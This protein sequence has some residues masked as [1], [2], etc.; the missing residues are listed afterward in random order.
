[1]LT[2]SAT[3]AAVLALFSAPLLLPAAALAQDGQRIEITGSRI[4]RL[5]N[6]TATQV[7]TLDV[8]QLQK[9]GV[10]NAEQAVKFITQQQGGTVTSSS[11]SGTNGAAAYADLRSLGAGRTLVLLNGKRVAPNPFA[12]VGTDLN[13]LPLAAVARIETLA[14]GASSIYGTDA[15]AGVINFIT[16][17]DVQGGSI[18]AGIQSTQR[19]GGDVASASLL[20]G[21]GDLSKQGFNVYAGLSLRKQNPMQGDAR[22]FSRTSYQ[23]ERG[24]NALSPTAFPANYNQTGTVTNA[25]VTSPNCDPPGSISVPETNGTRIRCFADTQ[26][27]TNTVPKQDQNSLFVKGTVGLGADHTASAEYFRSF[28]SVRTRI[29][30]SP[31]GG[32]TMPQ[33]SPFYPGNGTYAANPALNTTRPISL[34]WRTTALGSRAGQQDNV[35]ERLVAGLE[36]RI[37]GWDYSADGTY[38]T[39]KVDNEF[40]NGYPNTLG[41]RA[42]VAGCATG[43]NATTGACTTPLLDGAGNRVYL[44]PFG[45][46]TPAG[47]TYLESIEINGPVQTGKS[48]T[49][50]VNF[51]VSRPYAKLDGGDAV[52]AIN[53][54][55]RR[56]S[57]IYRTDIPKVSQAASSGLAGSGALRE[58]GRS[59]EAVSVETNVPFAKNMELN[60]AV[61]HDRY[62]GF[63]TT[64]N[65]KASFRWQPNDLWLVRAS[66]NTGF[67]APS[68]YNLNL[69][70]STTFTGTRYNDP[71]LCPG[72]VP[73][74]AA[75]AVP[76]RDCGI[77]FQ[78]LIGGNAN[79]K[80]EKSTAWT[81]G[82]AVQPV[83]ELTLGADY[84]VYNIKNSISTIGDQAV[85]ADTTKYAN[86]IL[87]CSQVSAAL[88]TSLGACQNPGSADPLAYVI[89]TFNNL[90]DVRT[91][92]V[93]FQ[94]RYATRA[95]SAGRWSATYRGTFVYK[96]KF[97]IEPGGVFFDPVSNYNAQFAGPVI[98]YQHVINLDWTVGNWSTQLTNRHVHGYRDQNTQGAPFNVSPFN[99]RRVQ[100]Y[101]VGDVSVS[102][103]GFKNTAL[104]FGILNVL[105]Q[106]PPFTNQTSRFQARGYDDRFHNPLGRTFQ[107]SAKYDF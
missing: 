28:N 2:P 29:A 48:I 13:T 100:A 1:L 56:E 37:L 96:Y 36:G 61:R 79:L 78:R 104:Q 46:Q 99:T 39:A 69:P 45:A 64:T 105:D 90:G 8:E 101:S 63:G 103:T 35:T 73:N 89:D 18:G 53:A 77:Q 41:L 88:R 6:E 7:V 80:P 70:N 20:G 5:A 97:Q 49:K 21:F 83:Q 19:G 71:V 25:N 106:D 81:I 86:L 84:W 14:D 68:L 42:G 87:R 43:F 10:T 57:M 26:V 62:S 60:L 9:A 17:K 66:A 92:G 3:R 16:K 24:Y 98:R 59:I 94:A 23:P 22:S 65:P 51:T 75:G 95:T 58:G 107:L 76:A 4:K 32:L 33:S 91:T 72:G 102:Y 85:F 52:V 40:L 30:P 44:N 34:A 12:V 67:A 54:E 82:A 38:S 50:A 93:D 47:Q 31:E 15:I 55:A 11:V 74:T 27:F